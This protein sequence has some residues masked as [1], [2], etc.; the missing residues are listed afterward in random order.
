MD[1]II[2]IVVA[3]ALCSATAAAQHP[4]VGGSATSRGGGSTGPTF[5]APDAEPLIATAPTPA[6]I[7]A[8]THG[9]PAP[10]A[11]TVDPDTSGQVASPFSGLVR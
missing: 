10:G 11:P 3:V 4:E 2:A 1:R 7:D 9:Q 6:D 8:R 5:P